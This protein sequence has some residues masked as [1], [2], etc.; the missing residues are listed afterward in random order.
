MVARPAVMR[1]PRRRLTTNLAPAL[2]LAL[3]FG[4]AGC[5]HSSLGWHGT[6]AEAEARARDLTAYKRSHERALGSRFVRSLTPE[7]FVAEV[8]RAR[9][10]W[11]GDR[12]VDL[13]VHAGWRELLGELREAGLQLSLALEAIGRDDEPAVANFL[14][15]RST[16][17]ELRAS[18]RERWPGSWLEPG[19]VDA[20]FYRALLSDAREASEPVFALEPAPRLPLDQRD[21]VIAARVAE[22]VRSQPGRVVVVVVGH[23][24]L[25]GAGDV[26]AR[27][28]VGGVIVA[29]ALNDMLRRARSA[30]REA[31]AVTFLA[32]DT[33]VL[34]PVWLR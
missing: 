24:H 5:D 30:R 9:V 11:L 17:D 21:A 13:A 8:T 20:S 14:A 28:N 3:S 10:L 29:P 26:V 34:F 25:L 19:D 31:A 16:M 7:D 12:H 33:G 6:E 18:V 23:A 15:G 1:P 22:L 27:A 32:S 4:S 2:A